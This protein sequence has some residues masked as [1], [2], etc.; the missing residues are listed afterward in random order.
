MSGKGF[1]AQEPD[2]RCE[3]CGKVAETRPYGPH[4]E[5]VCF[6]CGMKDEEAARRQFGKVVLGDE[7]A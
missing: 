7:S 4:G 1:I 2:R 3:L 6:D 5:R